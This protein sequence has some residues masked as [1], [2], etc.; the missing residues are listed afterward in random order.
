[1]AK[2]IR[3]AGWPAGVDNLSPETALVADDQG[4]VLA[5]REAENVDLV[6]PGKPRRRK[7]YAEA[8]WSSSGVHSLWAPADA[9]WGLIVRA[10]TLCLLRD[11]AHPEVLRDLA[12]PGEPVSYALVG[13]RVYW[14][15]GT[16]RGLVTA[17]GEDAPW[18]CPTPAGLPALALADAGA[19]AAGRYHV[20]ITYALGSGEESGAPTPAWIDVPDGGGIALSGVPQP[21]A[22]SGVTEIRVY[23]SAPGGD[24]LH[25]AR[26][27][28][29]GVT[30][31]QLGA[32][33][34]GR[35]LDT[36]GLASMP[37][38]RLVRVHAGRLW[39][40]GDDGWLV[41]SEALRYGLTE[42]PRNR[43]HVTGQPSLLEAVGG[44]TDGAGMYLAAGQR[45]YFLAGPP[46]RM[47]PAVSYPHGAVPG[48]AI[49]VP[50]SALGLE[51]SAQVAY[52]LA[53]NGAAV[54]GL[55]GGIVQPLR[56][57]QAVAPSAKRGASMYRAEDGSRRIVT[58]LAGTSARGL[59]FADSAT[60]TITRHD[61]A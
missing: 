10:G 30:E 16:D 1:M 28:L 40:L 23:V 57:H 5:L 6:G 35:P 37:A 7:G 48:T 49:C 27:L 19:L 12:A 41:W 47:T 53:D 4:V 13:D 21:P 52:W 29:V 11:P 55:P 60:S 9:P 15:N 50:G 18:G 14:S 45:T 2:P 33:Q 32:G 61:G 51:T 46:E 26:S 25:R 44:G 36:Q 34:R 56:E 38:G 58:T 39:C 43:L 42:P 22:D 59:A 24:V 3:H 8:L 20:S 54:V 17:A 31:T